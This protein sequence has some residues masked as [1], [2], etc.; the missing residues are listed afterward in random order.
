LRHSRAID[1]KEISS[2]I[3]TALYTNMK[4]RERTSASSPASPMGVRS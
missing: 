4:K 1:R 3:A 2:G